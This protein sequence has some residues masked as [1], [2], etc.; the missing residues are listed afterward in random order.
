MAMAEEE[1]I[2]EFKLVED[3]LSLKENNPDVVF[4]KGVQEKA[5]NL[6]PSDLIKI[7]K[8]IGSAINIL[9]IEKATDEVIKNFFSL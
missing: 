3:L 4:S 1:I 7:E 6:D 5:T 8:S 2:I 9:S